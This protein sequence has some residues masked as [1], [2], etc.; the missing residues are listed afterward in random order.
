MSTPASPAAVA[1]NRSNASL[2]TGP[3]SSEGKAKSSLNAVK[4]GLTGRTVLLP[5][6]DAAVYECHVQ[7]YIEDLQPVGAREHA[8]AQAL[9]DNAWRLD[10]IPA[11]EM[12]IYA[13]GRT[14]FANQFEHED[15]ALRPGLI[16]VH[17]YLAYEK[18]LRNLSL[19]EARLR[20]QREK[21]TVE[22]RQ[23]QQER[24]QKEK[25]Q[26]EAA[27]KL[28]TAAKRDNKPVDPAAFG[29]VFSSAEI[30]AF[31]ARGDMKTHLRAA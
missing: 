30:D 1:A 7:R 27:A 3:K 11:L 20:R 25:Q 16:E 22:L 6:E 14:Q 8:L 2:S 19:Q 24:I 21:D 12:A 17:T 31:L 23:L 13:V 18:Q 5:S 26:L 4:T 10:R 29:F 28:Y 9:A 15:P